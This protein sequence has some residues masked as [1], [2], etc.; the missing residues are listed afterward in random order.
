VVFDRRTKRWSAPE[1][2]TI[3]IDGEALNRETADAFREAL[4][5]AAMYTTSS[6]GADMMGGK[7][8]PFG[9]TYRLRTKA[10]APPA[11]NLPGAAP[12]SPPAQTQ[13]SAAISTSPGPPAAGAGEPV[14]ANAPPAP[15]AGS[16]AAGGASR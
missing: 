9:F 12:G 2:M 7:R 10:S 16:S 6:T 4:V 1:Q 13:A 5:Q 15:D 3:V 14:I 8:M 11:E